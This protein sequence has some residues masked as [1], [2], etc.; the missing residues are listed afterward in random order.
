MSIGKK[1]TLFTIGSAL[2][3]MLM[4]LGVSLYV[5]NQQTRRT[6][7]NYLS[8]A[9]GYAR[10]ILMERNRSIT[11]SVRLVADSGPFQEALGKQEMP[12]LMQTVQMLSKLFPYNDSVM[13]VDAD[14][15]KIAASSPSCRLEPESYVTKLAKR[16]MKQQEPQFAEVVIPL[17][18]MYAKASIPYNNLIVKIQDPESGQDG[19]LRKALVGINVI[20]VFSD[21]AH[22]EVVGG[23]IVL[24]ALNN[25]YY[26]PREFTNRMNGVYLTVSIDGVRITSNIVSGK[27][28]N[29]TG[30]RTPRKSE[31]TLVRG[32][33]YF[34][35]QYFPEQKEYHVFLD[36]EVNSN[37]QDGSAM[38]GI[39]IP[40]ERFREMLADRS[41][42]LIA[43][44]ITL[45]VI[46]LLVSKFLSRIITNPIVSL[47]DAVRKY[48]EVA[49]H[50]F[51]HP[52]GNGDEIK[53]LETIFHALIF[54]LAKKEQ[55]RKEYL[56]QLLVAN[57]EQKRLADELKK[58]N[59]Q[60]EF[61]VDER[62]KNLQMAIQELKTVDAAK[63]AFMANISHELRTPLNIIIGSAEA[64]YEGLWGPLTEKQTKYVKNIY[65]SGSH[66]LQL[67]NDVME[68]SK[69][70]MGKML[71]SLERF[72]IKD[73]IMQSING[74]K[75]L[76]EGK[77]L[78]LRVSLNPEDFQVVC[79]V[80]KLLEIMYNLLSNAVKFTGEGGQVEVR[81]EQGA[82]V[83]HIH[84]KD[85]GIGIAEADQERIFR[86]FEQVES[87]YTKKYPG[88]GLGLPIV[89][90]IVELMGGTVKLSSKL[91]LGTEI[92][93][94]IPLNVENVL[95]QHEEARKVDLGSE[96]RG[97]A[98]TR[99][100]GD[101]EGTIS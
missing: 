77:N 58:N 96:R 14:G 99:K 53:E 95:H 35:R 97:A 1:I 60:L 15:R 34:G 87:G 8:V 57:E 55:E 70:T 27:N 71:L 39:G 4:L 100:P 41:G 80:N 62:T 94:T 63:S 52:K 23:I 33:Q 44:V 92:F 54:Q 66:Q 74:I 30:S 76:A 93:I 24:D 16:S 51:K 18:D 101:G 19:T 36:Q 40:E 68:I 79:D 88:T 12:V 65:D 85:N 32:N 82:D 43:A 45:L 61:M 78:S 73:V 42:T 17:E 13:I 46:M 9:M 20:P 86:E 29:Y 67:I 6:E 21:N 26:F 59:D 22:T 2:M 7:Q 98:E 48:G 25:D 84:V 3:A 37:R 38:I 10:E 64:L 11:Q 49:L 89:K 75:P 83:F 81:I 5:F 91:G 56:Q 90:K 31:V 47:I 50:D 28:S 72:N 69:L